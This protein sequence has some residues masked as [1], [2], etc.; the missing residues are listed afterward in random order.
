M[1]NQVNYHFVGNAASGDVLDELR[2]LKWEEGTLACCDHAWGWPAYCQ[3][4]MRNWPVS[5]GY[6]LRE[7]AVN[8]IHGQIARECL[9]AGDLR[10][11]FVVAI[12]ADFRPF[13]FGQFEIVQNQRYAGIRCVYMPHLPQPGLIRRDRNRDSVSNICFSGQIE[14]SIDTSILKRDLEQMGCR[15][16]FREQGQWQDMHDVDVLFGIRAFSE[17]PFHSKPP[18]KLF[19][20]WHAGIPFIG[21]Y[22]SAYEQV[23]VP[24]ENYLR[25]SSYEDLLTAISRLKEDSDLYQRLVRAGKEA[26]KQYTPERTTDRW[27]SFFKDSV[28][29]RYFDW[30]NGRHSFLRPLQFSIGKRTG[31]WRLVDWF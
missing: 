18:S 20:A 11:H 9:T 27:C 25:V 6:E 24:G 22:D 4:K 31:C 17:E 8:V 23:G 26:G 7:G 14:N 29:P 28:D 19:N 12:R 3:L 10:R 21:G 5:F 30:V 13:P 16:V 15:L 2:A 1:K